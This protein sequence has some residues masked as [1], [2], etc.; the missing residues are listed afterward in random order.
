MKWSWVILEMAVVPFGVTSFADP[1]ESGMAGSST[2]LP[3][4]LVGV[5]ETFGNFGGCG[6]FGRVGIDAAFE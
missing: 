5:A 2:G 1:F 3:F 6:A 4:C